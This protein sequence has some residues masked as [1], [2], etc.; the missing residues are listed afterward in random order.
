MA[1]LV[2]GVDAGLVSAVPLNLM[3]RFNSVVSGPLGERE[4]ARHVL[5]LISRF[6][7]IVSRQSGREGIP[8][9]NVEPNKPVQWHC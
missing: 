4:D 1:L 9:T 8:H 5:N 6:N 2:V 7:G 3:S